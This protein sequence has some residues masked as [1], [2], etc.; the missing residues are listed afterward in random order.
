MPRIALELGREES[1]DRRH[2]DRRPPAA[3]K[4][5]IAQHHQVSASPAWPVFLASVGLRPA[6]VPMLQH[7]L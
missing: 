6:P 3:L 7:P 5:Q 1:I 4:E 2:G